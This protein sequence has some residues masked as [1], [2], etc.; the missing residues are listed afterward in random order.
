MA[1]PGRQAQPLPRGASPRPTRRGLAEFSRPIRPAPPVERDSRRRSSRP[2]R[3]FVERFRRSDWRRRELVR[4]RSR[5]PSRA[6]ST[7]ARG[8]SAGHDQ[9]SH[10]DDRSAGRRS[11]HAGWP[12]P[13]S[14]RPARPATSSASCSCAGSPGTP[15]ASSAA[16]IT[17]ARSARRPIFAAA[18]PIGGYD[19]HEPY[20]DRVRQGDIERPLRSGDRGPDVRDDLGNDQPAQDDPGHAASRSATIAKAGRSGASWR[21]TPIREMLRRRAAADP[22]ARQR[23]A[24]ELHARR[25][26]P[27]ARSPA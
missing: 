13:F 8:D 27:A 9:D 7:S 12:R 2:H 15:T 19:R 4:A 3:G 11:V 23:L 26:F 20:I 14:T 16:T 1:G 25:A 24:G 6:D 21:S 18:C 17:S 10:A 22:S 5:L